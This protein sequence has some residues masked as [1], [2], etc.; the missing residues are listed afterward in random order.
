MFAYDRADSY[1]SK[2][3][4]DVVAV[5]LI[6]GLSALLGSA[7]AYFASKRQADRA[8]EAEQARIRADLDRLKIQHGEDHARHRQVVYH[9]LLD[10][11]GRWH[12]AAMT[13]PMCL[14]EYKQWVL[15][16]EHCLNAVLLV[17]TED[18]VEQARKLQK[19][20]EDAWELNGQ[21]YNAGSPA[22]GSV[23]RQIEATMAAMR[24]DT[25]PERV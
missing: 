19:V 18:V 1:V 16:S 21:N 3:M 8:S 22:H 11:I 24:D 7:G 17:G 12:I 5:A 25:A 20:V 10:I 13:E 23:V 14:N 2:T 15:D 4:D 6:T 9:D